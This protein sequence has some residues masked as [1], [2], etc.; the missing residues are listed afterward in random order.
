MGEQNQGKSSE[1]VVN[2]LLEQKYQEAIPILD[3]L[4]EEYPSHEEYSVYRS[5]VLR[6]LIAHWT[7]SRVDS[8]HTNSGGAHRLRRSLVGVFQFS[9]EKLVRSLREI[10]KGLYQKQTLRIG[11]LS[12]A[13]LIVL[14][15]IQEGNNVKNPKPRLTSINRDN[16]QSTM[17]S[18]ETGRRPLTTSAGEAADTDN[19]PNPLRTGSDE[20]PSAPATAQEADDVTVSAT[21]TVRAISNNQ[22]QHLTASKSK[23]AKAQIAKV[24]ARNG[25]SNKQQPATVVSRNN[26]SALAPS[27]GKAENNNDAILDDYRSARP[28]GLRKSP[29]FAAEA[30]GEIHT[31]ESL[32]VREFTGSWAKVRLKP[33][34][35]V[36]F[37]RRELLVPITKNDGTAKGQTDESTNTTSTPAP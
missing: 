1:E 17:L 15:G 27:G 29:S 14:V 9:K 4:I 13:I 23:T 8:G 24:S 20:T 16:A 34:G 19:Q 18:A 3:A 10:Y 37:V 11:V 7:L 32:D 6:I 36:G 25:A 28:I 35:A 2:L 12:C 5:L 31:G 22:S 26:D 21:G 33:S 30:I